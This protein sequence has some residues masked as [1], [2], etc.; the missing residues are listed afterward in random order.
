MGNPVPGPRLYRFGDC[1]LD[2]HTGEVSRGSSKVRLRE[3]PLQLLIALLEQPGALVTREQLVA[4]LWDPGTFVDFDRGLNK[5]VNHLRESL[6][7][8]RRKSP[9][10]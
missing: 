7:D 3:Q 5:A 10:H 2:A 4:R 6:G 8:F 9:L 1:T